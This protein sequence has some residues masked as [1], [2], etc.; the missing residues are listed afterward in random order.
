MSSDLSDYHTNTNV[1][2]ASRQAPEREATNR[3]YL[4]VALDD[5]EEGRV[6]GN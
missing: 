4:R 1:Q 5:R 2:E 3:R 6:K